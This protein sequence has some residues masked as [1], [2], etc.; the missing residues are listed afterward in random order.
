MDRG[1]IETWLMHLLR[2]FDRREVAFDFVVDARQ[3]AAYDDEIESLGARI[4]RCPRTLNY[5]SYGLRLKRAISAHGPYDVI[6][7]H[8]DQ[9]S[10]FVLAVAARL[11][12]PIR[13]AH[14]HIDM[15]VVGRRSD[16]LRRAYYRVLRGLLGAN[17]THGI[18][19]SHGAAGDLFGT[20]YASD[21]RVKI[22]YCG[23]DYSPFRSMPPACVVRAE[24]GISQDAKV[25][26]H[27]GRFDPQ[28]NHSFLID[29]FG[30]RA[31]ADPRLHLLL[32]GSGP[33]KPEAEGR[34]RGLG[35]E[36][37]V[38]FA[39]LQSDVPKMLAAMD[40][41][42]LPSLYE[43]LPLVLMEAQAAG[44][45][46]VVSDSITTEAIIGGHWARRIPTSDAHV[47]AAAMAEAASQP[48]NCR[49]KSVDNRFDINHCIQQLLAI[50]RHQ[51]PIVATED[52]YSSPNNVERYGT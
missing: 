10:G 43:G 12:I 41:F 51:D 48:A 19:V 24:F 47:W 18:G 22:I 45:P 21:P 35:L 8:T 3:R 37:R 2:R 49:A 27:V 6:H 25:I 13:V 1:G 26:G 4:I 30:A 23:I 39:G 32:V 15:R 16:L 34:V 42:A 29:A 40:A 9:I 38:T 7:S 28:K 33:L 11:G 17:M 20:D 50:Y 31:T 52:P 36:H 44:L 14:S 46:L 5:A